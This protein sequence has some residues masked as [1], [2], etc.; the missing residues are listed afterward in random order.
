MRPF[1]SRLFATACLALGFVLPA[2]WA[3]DSPPTP[4]TTV[5]GVRTEF[6]RVLQD[7]DL[8][9]LAARAVPPGRRAEG[10]KVSPADRVRRAARR[11][12]GGRLARMEAERALSSEERA[13][14]R[15]LV[16]R[17]AT[18]GRETERPLPPPRTGAPPPDAPAA[19]PNATGV[20]S[21]RITRASDGAGIGGSAVYLYW[22]TAWGSSHRYVYADGSGNYSFT[23]LDTGTYYVRS[24]NFDGY[25]DEAW[26][27][28]P[29]DLSCDPVTVGTA[30][31][32]TD[33]A[34]TPNINLALNAGGRITGTVLNSATSAPIEGL[35]LSF[36][37]AADGSGYATY[38]YTDGA[39]VFA[40]YGG[41][42][43]GT[44]FVM[45]HT[46]IGSLGFVDEAY[47]NIPC[48]F[49]SCSPTTGTP[50]TVTSPST[51]SGIN[52][53]LDPGGSVAGTVTDAGTSAGL[54]AVEVDIYGLD[55]RFDGYGYTDASGNYSTV[56]NLPTGDYV[57][58]TR[59]G[60]GYLDEMWDGVLCPPGYPWSCGGVGAATP[61]HVAVGTVTNDIDFALE[62]GGQIAGKVTDASTTT[63][64]PYTE[65]DIYTED[66]RFVS[67]T[68]TDGAG[69]YTSTSLPEGRYRSR[70]SNYSGYVNEVHDDKPCVGLWS[71][72]LAEGI[73]V[74]VTQGATTPGIDF[75]LDKGGQIAGQVTDASTSAGVPDVE[76][77]IYSPGGSLMAYGYTDGTGSYATSV[78]GLPTGRHYARTYQYS[79][80]LYI[81]EAYSNVTCAA[82][83][84]EINGTPI[85]VTLGATTPGID[86]A[87]DGGGSIAGRITSA[88]DGAGI[89]AGAYAYTMNGL[90][91]RRTSADASGNYV[92]GGLPSGRYVVQTRNIEGFVD[93]V[94]SDR[95]CVGSR[96]D[97]TLGTA[98]SVTAGSAT[99]LNFALSPGAGISGRV[100]DQGTGN[101]IPSVTINLLK[102]PSGSVASLTTDGLGYF[103]SGPGSGYGLPTG[104]YYVQ[105]AN[106][107]GYQDELY[108]NLPCLGCDVTTGTKVQLKAGATT[109]GIN[110][111]LAKGVAAGAGRIAGKV[112]RAGTGEPLALFSVRIY[113]STGHQVNSLYTDFLGNYLSGSLP[114]G[115]Y[116]VAAI[117]G[118]S[119]YANELYSNVPLCPACSPTTGTPVTVTAGV[120]TAS[121]DIALDAG[122]R[123]EGRVTDA[124]TSAPLAYASVSIYD[125]GSNLVKSASVDAAGNY[126]VNGLVPG[127]YYALAGAGSAY[128]K[129]LFSGIPCPACSPA[130]GT[131]ITVTAG[132]TASGR[133][134]ALAAGGRIEGTVTHASEGRPVSASVTI[135]DAAGAIA[136]GS[137]QDGSGFYRS[138]S[139][140]PS[141]TYYARAADS[142][143]AYDAE[144]YNNRPCNSCDPTTGDAVTVASPGAT[145]GVD[146][147]LDA[148]SLDF[149]T[150]APCRVVDT[151][152]P[153]S[154]F[155][156]PALASK[157]DRILSVFAKCGIPLTARALSINITATG[158]TTQG[159]LRLHPGDLPV[160]TASSLNYAAGQ[161]RANNAVVPL[162]RFGELAVYCGQAA[163]T[164]HFIIDVNG[165]FQ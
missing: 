54:S 152:N 57:A 157:E 16:H 123:I 36:F 25:L 109:T 45:T 62:K 97:L 35:Y 88:A 40:S 72:P 149:Y 112:T 30:I 39:G 63:G 87:L 74:G 158:S 164:V 37:N 53:A 108:D 73:A 24:N 33:G 119:D 14:W 103:E 127:T 128:V 70:T 46:E 118:A 76:V 13:A 32:V 89:A 81:D 120:T 52:F 94:Y 34:T 144:L 114:A 139:G 111:A 17:H 18:R 90:L 147:T 29:C 92:L 7:V 136:A 100:T 145:T 48:P 8:Y 65:V 93:E 60:A 66:G 151:R 140:L 160:P 101:G 22:T 27:N 79:G 148:R 69:D 106:S 153:P 117:V 9:L 96:C 49:S 99:P 138:S 84:P 116:Y 98:V 105:T 95:P 5:T 44:Y 42:V 38:A 64:L 15:D 71:C 146:F 6:E 77:D 75:A 165:Y 26:N 78:G 68:Y 20:L 61:I 141:G 102:P 4:A 142:A 122:G 131:P 59:N 124:S 3:A 12:A 161:T 129:Q 31:P 162:S 83:R 23:G 125:T 135:Y 110:F 133:D 55:G 2:V 58:V 80:G 67:H 150:L 113:D 19:L 126:A 159:H 47:D 156:G 91:V 1:P 56:H 154:A 28:V 51:T 130:T 163:G 50:I 43:S 86:F 132:G 11:F 134:F 41:L 155:G 115:T 137:V 121:I 10:A 21:G 85:D 143:G 104:G 107:L 82:C